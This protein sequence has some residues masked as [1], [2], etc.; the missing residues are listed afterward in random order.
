MNGPLHG[1]RVLDMGIVGTGPKTGLLLA[2]LGA[3][4]IKVESPRFPDPFRFAQMFPEGI[5]ASA[6]PWNY[7][8]GANANNRHKRSVCLE[9][10]GPEGAKVLDRLIESS[11]VLLHNFRLSVADKAG[12][13]AERVHSI[14][15]RIVMIALSSQGDSGPRR[16]Y[17][18]YGA[19]LEGLGGLGGLLGTP[20]HPLITTVNFPDQACP[21][22]AAGVIVRALIERDR[23]GRGCFIDFAQVE[24]TALL[25]AD[26]I[27]SSQLEGNPYGASPLSGDEPRGVFP[28]AGHDE[29]IAVEVTGDDSWH[30]LASLIGIDPAE[31]PA[32]RDRV[33]AREYLHTRLGDWTAA[34]SPLAAESELRNAGVPAARMLRGPEVLQHPALEARA[35]FED[36][37]SSRL[38]NR[39]YNG[40]PLG[41]SLQPRRWVPSAA[42]RLGEH[43]REVLI[44]VGFTHDEIDQ[45]EQMRLLGSRPEVSTR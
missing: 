26:V 15:P 14:N 29:W 7:A 36:I 19:T 38:G 25:S 39:R 8:V 41:P 12:I 45:L 34:R 18:S 9:Y 13:T 32:R 11:D 6:E 40:N 16:N 30:R 44:E 10:Q 2:W 5:D 43:N 1:I 33:A 31:F 28:C 24:A 37:D 4:V 35:Y 17:G 3:D 27:L 42:A 22:L 21:L 23:T 20:E